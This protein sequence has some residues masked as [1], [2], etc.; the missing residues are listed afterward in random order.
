MFRSMTVAFL[1]VYTAVMG[2]MVV[3]SAPILDNPRPYLLQ[4]FLMPLGLIG[5][6]MIIFIKINERKSHSS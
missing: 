3:T 2:S 4:Y 1:F 6:G 5:I